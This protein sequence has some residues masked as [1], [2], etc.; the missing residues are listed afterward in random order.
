[1]RHLALLLLV[2]AFIAP[3]AVAAEAPLTVEALYGT[4]APDAAAATAEQRA[5]VDAA[6]KL[7]GY[8][9]TFT[10][11]I[12]RVI[13]SEEEAYSGPWRLDQAAAGSAVLVVQPKGGE[14]R[15]LKLALAGKHL[16]VDGGL[17]LAKAAR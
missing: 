14:E 13:F 16:R 5:D 4:W 17:P 15:R 8:G 11:R 3:A 1:M 7:E 2:L 10:A 6:A 9:I 12:C